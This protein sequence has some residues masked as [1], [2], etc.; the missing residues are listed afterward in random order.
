MPL[1]EQLEH[2][3]PSYEK[4]EDY[5]I[6]KDN[7]FEGKIER[8]P[9]Y[10]KIDEVYHVYYGGDKVAKITE[11][12]LSRFKKLYCNRHGVTIEQ[13]GLEFNMLRA[14][15]FAIKSA[16][17]VVKT[18]IPYTNMEIDSMSVEEIAEETRIHK[19]KA[20]F[21]RLDEIKVKDMEEELKK[22]HQKD[23]YYNKL[24]DKMYLTKFQN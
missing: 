4:V 19:K 24:I 11:E 10:E 17:D 7:I 18:S 13:L 22:L 14:E 1:S 3:S 15:V 8:K 12:E 9:K 2:L 20:Y 6:G 5:T 21:K 23:Y 16:F